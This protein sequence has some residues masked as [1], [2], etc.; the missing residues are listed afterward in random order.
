MASSQARH[1]RCSSRLCRVLRRHRLVQRRHCRWCRRPLLPLLALRRRTQTHLTG[2]HSRQ[3]LARP[4]SRSSRHPQFRLAHRPHLTLPSRLS[5]RTHPTRC[6]HRLPG[7]HSDRFLLATLRH[8]RFSRRYRL[9]CRRTGRHPRCRSLPRH[10]AAT[11]RLPLAHPSHHHPGCHLRLAPHRWYR[12]RVGPLRRRVHH[13][14]HLYPLSRPV[15]PRHHPSY[16]LHRRLRIRR[17]SRPVRLLVRRGDRPHLHSRLRRPR[18]RRLSLNL[19]HLSLPPRHLHPH[20]RVCLQTRSLS[21]VLLIQRITRGASM[22]HPPRGPRQPRS[23]RDSRRPSQESRLRR[24]RGLQS[25][26]E[27]DRTVPNP[28]RSSVRSPLCRHQSPSIQIPSETLSC[29]S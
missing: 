21:A 19:R 2:R 3:Q 9:A 27:R 5:H 18:L 7:R 11:P 1:H 28:G 20:A 6:H 17:P 16:R 8:H 15:A 13:F 22:G 24:A 29:V 14:L 26:R 10:R 4:H 12:P 23:V 25:L